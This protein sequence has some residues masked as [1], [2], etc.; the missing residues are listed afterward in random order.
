[1]SYCE[2]PPHRALG[3][4]IDAY[5]RIETND[6]SPGTAQRILP[7]GCTDIIFN[8]ENTI[9]RPDQ[10]IAM[11]SA[12][13]YLIGTMTTFS[14]IIRGSGQSIL[15]I[16]FKPGCFRAF[17]PLDLHEITNVATAFRLDGLRE[18]VYGSADLLSDLDFYFLQRMP[19][20]ALASA[21]VL[22][23]IQSSRGRIKVAELLSNHAMSERKLERLFLREVGVSMKGM[24]RLTR[25]IHTLDAIQSASAERSLSAIAYAHGYY[26]QA[27]LCA[28]V[29]SF[30]GLTPS[31][32]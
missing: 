23:D 11:R 28:E 27:H 17:F 16:R 7:D 3:K 22:A 25:F 20:Q 19:A 10:Q 12:E 6:L 8:K 15:G 24:I 26:D 1:M 5:W 14:E 4:Y 30:S 32:L 29:K 9:Y 21:A 18:I 13:T 2:Y 31:Q